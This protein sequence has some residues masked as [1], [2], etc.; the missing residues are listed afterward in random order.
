MRECKGEK[1]RGEGKGGKEGL[2]FCR[3]KIIYL[4]GE[5]WGN[6]LP[7]T[8]ALSTPNRSK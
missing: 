5:R 6:L 8:Q 1:G 4:P 2:L 3:F 7:R